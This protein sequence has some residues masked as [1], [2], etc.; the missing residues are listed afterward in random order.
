[1]KIAVIGYSKMFASIIEAILESKH[2][3]VGVFRHDR[4]KYSPIRLFF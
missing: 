4:V 3:L 2:E 1:M